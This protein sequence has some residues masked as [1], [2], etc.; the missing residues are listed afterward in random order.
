MNNELAERNTQTVFEQI[1]K[2]DEDGNEFW[3]ARDLSKVLDYSEYRHFL[4]V[5]ERAKES[6][7]NSGQNPS[8]HYEDMLDMI[9]IGKGGQRQVESVKFS[10]YACCRQY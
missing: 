2:I 3:S 8:D 4:P 6:C 1:K 10:R 7:Q 5:I 9:E